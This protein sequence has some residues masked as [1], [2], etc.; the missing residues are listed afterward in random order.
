MTALQVGL[1]NAGFFQGQATGY[2][3][4]KTEAA[5]RNFQRAYGL[6]V[7]GVA[8]P[9][10]LSTL[11]ATNCPPTILVMPGTTYQPATYPSYP[12]SP[13]TPC[14]YP[15]TMGSGGGVMVQPTYW[16]NPNGNYWTY[17]NSNY[18]V[19]PSGHTDHEQSRN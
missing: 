2:Y 17:P 9:S 18:V 12:Y 10:T 11:Y 7:D 13:C 3:G 16:V 8:G 5:V 1:R 14:A 6:R 15:N 19:T 4:S